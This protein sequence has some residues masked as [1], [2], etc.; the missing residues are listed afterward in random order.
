MSQR[1]G[2]TP[3][4][5]FLTPWVRFQGPHMSRLIKTML[6]LKCMERQTKTKWIKKNCSTSFA[7]QTGRL[8][9]GSFLSDITAWFNNCPPHTLMLLWWCHN[10][11]LYW[12]KS[13]L[14]KH[15]SLVSYPPGTSLLLLPTVSQC[16][17][18]SFQQHPGVDPH[19]T[20]H[21][22]SHTHHH[23]LSVFTCETGVFFYLFTTSPVCC[24]CS[25][26][27]L[28]EAASLAR[29]FFSSFFARINQADGVEH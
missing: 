28:Q 27:H 10:R 2:I 18:L 9:F 5:P 29:F 22:S 20:L 12:I 4:L 26:P 17:A 7:S 16:L 3:Y 14:I 19:S 25:R 23:P 8:M 6:T 11:F 1:A 24:C 15:I 21:S 13:Q